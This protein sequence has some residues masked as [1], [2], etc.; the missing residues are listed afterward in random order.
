MISL[1]YLIACIP[2]S[3]GIWVMFC[4]DT[5]SYLKCQDSQ[6]K[7]LVTGKRETS[8]TFLKRGERKFWRIQTLWWAL[9]V[10]GKG[11]EQTPNKNPKSHKR[12]GGNLRQRAQFHWGQIVPDQSGGL[13]WQ[14]DYRSHQGKTDRCHL[15]RLL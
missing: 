14:S 2:G 3:W 13:L 11:L 4:Q 9:A 15:S 1:W 5:P 6:V 10:P 7:S 8:L 12:Q